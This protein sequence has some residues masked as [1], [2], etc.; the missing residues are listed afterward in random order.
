M[1][2]LGRTPAPLPQRHGGAGPLRKSILPLRNT[3]AAPELRP[4]TEILSPVTTSRVQRLSSTAVYPAARRAHAFSKE[5]LARGALRDT[6]L[7]VRR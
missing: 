7:E 1:A 6:L 5:T 2:D 3:I 4:G